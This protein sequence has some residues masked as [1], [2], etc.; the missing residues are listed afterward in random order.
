[1][2]HLL[3]NRSRPAAWISAWLLCAAAGIGWICH[4]EFEAQRRLFETDSRI[5]HRLLTQRTVQ[6]DTILATLAAGGTEDAGCAPAAR[7]Q[8][9]RIYPQLVEVA[10][11]RMASRSNE[12]LLK[13]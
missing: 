3:T 1:M 7:A 9:M 13:A 12:M 5:A 2:R 8:V 10:C 11:S 4:S 6:H